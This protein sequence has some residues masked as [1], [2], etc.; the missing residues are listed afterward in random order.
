MRSDITSALGLLECIIHR[1]GERRMSVLG[2]L[3]HSLRHSL[4]KESLR[5]F[6]ATMTIGCSDELF[7]LRHRN[8]GEEI[9]YYM[10][11]RPTKP[12]VEKVRQICVCYV[13][14]VW[15][16]CRDNLSIAEYLFSRIKL[17]C[18]TA[19]SRVAIE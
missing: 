3:L 7:S 2:K 16:V 11:K 12:D 19:A 4:Q 15:R 10:S 13:V 1:N 9:R 14:V 6:H 17:F 5:F 18:L 8:S